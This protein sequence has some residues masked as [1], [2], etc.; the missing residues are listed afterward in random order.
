MQLLQVKALK[1]VSGA[2]IYPPL[3]F[4]VKQQFDL[5]MR[6]LQQQLSLSLSCTWVTNKEL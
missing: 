5:N 3:C 2:V 4:A 6:L 1:T